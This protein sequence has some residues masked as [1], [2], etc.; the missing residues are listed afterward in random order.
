[1]R[2]SSHT[3]AVAVV[4]AGGLGSRMKRAEQPK[5][6]V[7]VDGKPI[8]VRT[9]DHFQEH[10][11]VG[12]VYLSCVASRVDDAWSLVRTFGLDKVKDIVPG[13]ASAQESI[14]NGLCSAAEDGVPDD[15]IVLVHDGVRPLISRHLI[16]RNIA[17]ARAL[18]N[19]ITAIPCF[20]TVARS[21]DGAQTIDSVP[22]REQMHILQA[23]Q[24]FL[25]GQLRRS[26]ARS[27]EEGLMGTFV[28]QA[29][30]MKHYGEVLHL[31][32]GFRGNVKLT[33]DLDLLQY[34]LLSGSG[35]LVSV[36]GE[37]A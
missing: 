33:T 1:M 29:Q 6:F 23:P 17:T 30:L 28:D 13:G 31:V 19:G 14:Y 22:R 24:T 2:A 7:P 32:Q 12:S 21:V 10:V 20:E 16:S 27:A 15:A 3:D 34:Q 37:D 8:L 25:L 35:H 5:Q 11:E 4:F 9:L 36:I 18:G 26:N